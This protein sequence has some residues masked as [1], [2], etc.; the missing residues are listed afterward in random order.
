MDK[1]LSTRFKENLNI[2]LAFVS[3]KIIPTETSQNDF[4]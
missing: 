3:D 1:S 2:P 4:L